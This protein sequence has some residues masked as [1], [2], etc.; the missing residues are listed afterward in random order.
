VLL[1]KNETL[2]ASRG[3]GESRRRVEGVVCRWRPL[4]HRP[5]PP[6]ATRGIRCCFAPSARMRAVS[7]FCEGA[8]IPW[9]NTI[10]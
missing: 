1:E 2:N 7:A 4:R 10:S 5:Q 9:R 6:R 3:P 8:R